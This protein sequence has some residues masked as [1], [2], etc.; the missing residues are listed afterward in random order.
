M[1]GSVRS[2]T[3]SAPA[4][5]PKHGPGDFGT[6]PTG[7]WDDATIPVESMPRPAKVLAANAETWIALLDVDELLVAIGARRYPLDSV[8]LV[9]VTDFAVYADGSTEIRARMTR[10]RN[11][12]PTDP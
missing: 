1:G 6:D 7:L 11:P 5:F 12:P 3:P 8:A 2:P 4:A 9:E 10:Q